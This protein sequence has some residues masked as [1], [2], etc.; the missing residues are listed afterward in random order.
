MKLDHDLLRRAAALRMAPL[1]AVR[2]ER[3]GERRSARVGRGTD[4][5]D[6][7]PYT[8]GDDLRLVD[9]AAYARHESVVVKLFHEERSAKVVIVLDLS[10]SMGVEPAKLERAGTLAAALCQAGLAAQDHT[11]LVLAG[12]KVRSVEGADLRAWPRFTAALEAALADGPALDR[13]ALLPARSAA[14]PD[15]LLLISDLLSEE[16]EQESLLTA[17]S[18]GGQR[19]ALLQ[20]LGEEDLRP[21]LEG[22]LILVDAETN[23]AL[24]TDGQAALAAR[25]GALLA[26][27]R[28]RLTARA[29]WHRVDLIGADV[30]HPLPALLFEALPRLGLL[31]NGARA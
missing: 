15:R 11:Q 23:E 14:A 10:R 29:A 27:F 17:L 25:Y 2:G 19:S 5:A 8:A 4:L 31:A 16:V 20:V 22:E 7:R 12:A 30:D 18:R 1:R 26:E 3:Q 28:A 9:W 21:Q 6:H 13:A 24:P